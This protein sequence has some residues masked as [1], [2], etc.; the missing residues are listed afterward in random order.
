MITAISLAKMSGNWGE[1][2]EAA[3]LAISHIGLYPPKPSWPLLTVRRMGI[4]EL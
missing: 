2:S 4:G 1:S 3:K